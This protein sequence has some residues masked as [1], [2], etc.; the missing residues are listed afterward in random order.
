[1]GRWET[2]TG[3]LMGQ[4]NSCSTFYLAYLTMFLAKWDKTHG[5]ILHEKNVSEFKW[6]S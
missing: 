5:G 2:R 4:K 6:S 1:M 3:R